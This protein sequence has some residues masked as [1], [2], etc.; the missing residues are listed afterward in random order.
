MKEYSREQ[1]PNAVIVK[2]DAG[3]CERC[4]GE[5]G[6]PVLCKRHM[7]EYSREQFPNAVI[8]KVDEGNCARCKDGK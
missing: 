7:K 2:I 4:K 3:N 8:V 5:T 6:T 1:F